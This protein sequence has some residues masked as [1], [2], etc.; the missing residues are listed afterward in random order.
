LAADYRICASV[1]AQAATLARV[2]DAPPQAAARLRSPRAASPVNLLLAVAVLALLFRLVYLLQISRAPFFDIRIGDALAYH[3][4]AQRIAAGNWVGSDVFYQAPLYPYFLAAVYSLVGDSVMGVRFIQAVIGAAS[5]TLLAAAGI[6]LFGRRGVVAGVLLAVYPPAIFLD[7]LLDKSTLVCFLTTALLYLLSAGQVRFRELMAGVILGLLSLARENALLLALPVVAWFVFGRSRRGSRDSGATSSAPWLAAAAFVGGFAL[8]L[9]PV[10]LRNYAIGG[11]F[12]LTTSQFGPN[13]YIGNHAGASGLYD[14][15]VPGHGSAADERADAVRIAQEAAGRPLSASEVSSFWTRR[16]LDFIRAEP[17]AWLRLQVRKLA[18]TFNAIEIA[19]TESQ[20]VYA[21]WSSLLRGLSLFSFGVIACGAA[22]GTWLSLN[23]WRRLWWLYAV[24]AIYTLSIVSFY[25]FAR[26]RFPLVPLLLLLTAGGVA[27]WHD[28]SARSMR[29]GAV[30]AAVVAAIVAYLPI[31]STRPDRIAH[32]VNIGNALVRNGR[33]L[34]HAGSFYEKALLESPR[35]P[36]AHFGMATLMRLKGRPQDAIAHYRTA[37]EGWPDN[38]DLRLDFAAGL[39]EAGDP[40]SALD[41]LREVAALRPADVT[42][43]VA[44][45]KL[46]LERFRSADAAAAFERALAIDPTNVE[47]LMG[48]GD[49]LTQLHRPAE[50]LARFRSVLK[51]DP[52]HAD[53][54]ERLGRFQ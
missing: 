52:R 19:D 6:A 24:A 28:Q 18:L 49:A 1:R 44:V 8:V 20:D 11:E 26:Y 40:E 2:R 22:F 31:E 29:G 50:A 23:E 15:L 27:A 16:A 21:E 38:A 51:I 3:E 47:A 30:A 48:S 39:Q 53:A 41:Q 7:G 37:V 25:V 10:A 5:C 32:Y 4:W 54:R 45:G 33:T 9:T 43:Q 12:V 34:D 17:G 13:F 36:A 14:P 35:S 46:L 42:I